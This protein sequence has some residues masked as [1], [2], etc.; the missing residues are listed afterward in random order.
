MQKHV[1]ESFAKRRFSPWAFHRSFYHLHLSLS[2][3]FFGYNRVSFLD[4]VQWNSPISPPFIF[5]GLRS[6]FHQ[7][8]PQTRENPNSRE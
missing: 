4:E 8:M 2:L 1:C 5:T 3:R 6:S 7:Y